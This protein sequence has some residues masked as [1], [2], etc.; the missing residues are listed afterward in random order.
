MSNGGYSRNTFLAEISTWLVSVRAGTCSPRNIRIAIG[1][2]NLL[3]LTGAA[4]YGAAGA[5]A[6]NDAITGTPGGFNRGFRS[7]GGGVVERGDEQFAPGLSAEKLG[8]DALGANRM[9]GTVQQD[10]WNIGQFLPQSLRHSLNARGHGRAGVGDVAEDRSDQRLIGPVLPGE[11]SEGLARD[12]A[13]RERIGGVKRRVR[14]WMV[15]REYGNARCFELAADFGIG[16]RVGIIF[17]QQVDL[18]GNGIRRIG[19]GLPGV[20]AIVVINHV[21]RQA[22]RRKLEAAADFR[23]AKAQ[24]LDRRPRLLVQIGESHPKA[25]GLHAGRAPGRGDGEDREQ[26]MP[27]LHVKRRHNVAFSEIRCRHTT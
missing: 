23:P 1:R 2:T 7:E 12:P 3:L 8:E 5:L 14:N 17:D 27:A 16:F 6:D 26:E 25:P 13:G 21:Q 15:Q 18:A 4:M 11:L 19:N 22:A 24:A 10:R 20:A 9:T